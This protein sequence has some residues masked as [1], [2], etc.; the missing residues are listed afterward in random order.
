VLAALKKARHK[1]ERKAWHEAEQA[2]E[3]IVSWRRAL[4]A[5]AN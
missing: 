4:Q 3:T 1:C 2:G 5:K